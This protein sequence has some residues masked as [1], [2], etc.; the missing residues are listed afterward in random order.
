MKSP[1]S[2]LPA[3]AIEPLSQAAFARFGDVIEAAAA[4][5]TVA[6]N[7]ATAVRYPALATVDCQ[8]EGGTAMISRC[9]AAARALP[10]DI[11]LLERHPLG[12]QAFIP[13]RP[14]AYLVVV[15]KDPG[16]PP[17][18]FLATAGQG[19]NFHRGSWHHPLLALEPASE[20][21]IV[22]RVGPGANCETV[23]L[24]QCYQ[25]ARLD[26]ASVRRSRRQ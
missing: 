8:A 26:V 3:L 22:D 12:S 13:L 24:D 15:A 19:V 23:A 7:D 10:F 9:R 1:A 18:A 4:S 21:L 14:L 5:A 2:A 11:R 17:R 20:F 16:S 6:I 25:I